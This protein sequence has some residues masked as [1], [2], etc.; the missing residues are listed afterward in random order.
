M[1]EGQR[2]AAGLVDAEG[3][4]V[5]R[6]RIAVP[7]RDVWPGLEGLIGRVLAAAPSGTAGPSAVAVTCSGPIDTRAGSVSPPHIASWSNFPLRER[8]AGL[9]SLPVVLDSIAGAAADM[10]ASTAT[11]RQSGFL[12][13]LLGSSIDSAC[14]VTG[15]RLSG[16][17]GNA[18]SIAHVMVEPA[19]NSCWCGDSGCLE[20]YVASVAIESE[21]N[22]PLQ[23][24]TPSIVER[25]GIMFGRAVSSMAATVDISMVYVSGAVID[26]F[27]QPML[28]AARTEIKARS[29]LRNI[30]ELSIEPSPAA[31]PLVAAASVATA[32]GGEWLT[33]VPDE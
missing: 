19:G 8:L 20:A 31:P 33:A 21:L 3:S 26:A 13:V 25:T 7:S 18:G 11:E 29:R 14:V 17:H 10:R 32:G 2:L 15:M 1:I 6:D 9:T 22:R 30:A 16:A 24:A 4:V 27:G 5:V 12:E 23:R 28:E